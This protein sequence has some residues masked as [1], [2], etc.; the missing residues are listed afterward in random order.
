M[1]REARMTDATPCEVASARSVVIVRAGCRRRPGLDRGLLAAGRLLELVVRLERHPKSGRGD[2]RP[3]ETDGEIGADAGLAVH[4]A[5]ERDARHAEAL[6]GLRDGQ[7]QRL[8][9]VFLEELA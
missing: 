8:Q 1:R 3:F 7:I 9:N 2:A 5:G 6:R 4:D